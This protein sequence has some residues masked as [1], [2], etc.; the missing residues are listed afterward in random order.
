MNPLFSRGLKNPF[1]SSLP[2]LQQL[3]VAIL[4]LTLMLSTWDV[5]ACKCD[6]LSRIS[7]RDVEQAQLIVV[8]TCIS[9]EIDEAN[10]SRIMVFQVD[11]NLKK[12]DELNEIR[13]VTPMEKKNC[14]L[15]VKEGEEWFLWGY[16]IGDQLQ[17]SQCTRSVRLTSISY[18]GS[19]L[20]SRT[21]RKREKAFNK[22]V[23][24]YRKER[25]FIDKLYAPA[26]AEES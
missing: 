22:G 16:R 10:N 7:A 6:A 1:G 24:R 2:I 13:V 14:G 18:E 9:I 5:H 11:R 26:M 3:P 8:A 25:R 23:K 4:L 17:T 15:D 21:L 12:E 19:D 20:P